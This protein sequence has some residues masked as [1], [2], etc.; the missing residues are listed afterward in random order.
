WT[1]ANILRLSLMAGR[2]AI[3]ISSLFT[4]PQAARLAWQELRNKIEVFLTVK[5]LNSIL[6]ISDNDDRPLPQLVEKAYSLPPF[7]ALWAVE[8]LGHVYTASSWRVH[9]PPKRLLWKENALV[10]EKSLL[11]LHAGMGLFF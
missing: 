7:Q 8:G 4:D 10:P 9:G 3:R 11:M 5:N 2:Q 1:P 6:G